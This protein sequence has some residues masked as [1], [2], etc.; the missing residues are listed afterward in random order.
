VTL[1]VRPADP[2][3]GDFI[4]RLLVEQWHGTAVTSKRKLYNVTTLPCLVA[5]VDG[6]PTGLVALAHARG[7]TVVVLLE[8]GTPG[9][10]I[11]RALLHAAV[12]AAREAG[13]SRL[14]LTTTNDNVRALKFYLREGM[15]LVAVDLG[16]A[17]DA[18][19]RLKPAI[20]THGADGTPITDEWELE[21]AL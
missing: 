18:R 2:T 5:D 13:S 4:R 20:P 15:R 19:R 7:E 6:V 10:G 12:D 9:R 17:D 11:G 3:D 14:W 8:A 21:L 1:V 16:A